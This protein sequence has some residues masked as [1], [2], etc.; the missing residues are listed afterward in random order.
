MAVM[1]ERR[2]PGMMLTPVVNRSVAWART[3]TNS[4][5]LL[6]HDL[7]RKPVPTFRHHALRV[8]VPTD[9]RRQL[10]GAVQSPGTAGRPA[11]SIDGAR[12][13]V[14]DGKRKTAIAGRWRQEQ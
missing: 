6:E 11:R 3:R 4:R 9:V 12:E 7:F 13:R 8:Q 1:M 10:V 14:Q 2:M 5:S